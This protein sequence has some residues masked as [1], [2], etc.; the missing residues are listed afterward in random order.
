MI[1]VLAAMVI[2]STGATVLFGWIGQTSERLARLAGEQ[3][4]LFTDMV[5]LEYMKTVN[6]MLEP[7][8]EIRLSD[9]VLLRWQSERLPGDDTVRGPGSLY[10]LGL[11]RVKVRVS[12]P[13]QGV[14]ES[15][16]ELAGWRQVRQPSSQGPIREAGT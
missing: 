13:Q 1:E 16:V 6:P 5:V 11:Y 7:A 8:G 14:R 10:E 4:E 15:S 9:G 12:A 2:F 3:R